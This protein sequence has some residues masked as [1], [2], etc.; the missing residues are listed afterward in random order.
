MDFDVVENPLTPNKTIL[1]LQGIRGGFHVIGMV[2]PVRFIE[3]FYR[4]S[5][6]P[7]GIPLLNTLLHQVSRGCVP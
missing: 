2:V 1:K 5:E 3:Q 7:G 4:Y 6:V